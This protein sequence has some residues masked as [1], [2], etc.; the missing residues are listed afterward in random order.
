MAHPALTLAPATLDHAADLA[1]V[2]DPSAFTYSLVAIPPT[3]D[4]AG[5]R[6]HIQE[7]RR[8]YV[9]YVMLSDG[10]AV[11]VT[12]YLDIREAHRGVE[13]GCTWIGTPYRG[14]RVNPAAKLLMLERAFEELDCERVQL[15]C[16]GRNRHSMNAIAKLGATHEGNLRRHMILPD[17]YVRDTIMFSILRE[18]WPGVRAGLLERLSAL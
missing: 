17:G 15:K 1:E 16:D 8:L 9:P 18:E 7:L 2:A 3:Y 4:E 11:G 6:F 10:K 5:F 12:C 13:I 14:T